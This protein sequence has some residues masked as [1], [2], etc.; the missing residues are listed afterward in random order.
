VSRRH[1]VMADKDISES[2]DTFGRVCCLLL[3]DGPAPVLSLQDTMFTV[4]MN[5]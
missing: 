3:M 2:R 5:E 4:T 1:V